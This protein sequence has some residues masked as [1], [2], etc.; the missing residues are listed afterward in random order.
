MI[1]GTSLDVNANYELHLIFHLFAGQFCGGVFMYF[2]VVFTVQL[3]HAILMANIVCDKIR[4]TEEMFVEDSRSHDELS[5]NL[6]SVI[7]LQ[8]ELRE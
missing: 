5:K 2:D 4:V 1:P 8:N 3:L 6:R 7:E